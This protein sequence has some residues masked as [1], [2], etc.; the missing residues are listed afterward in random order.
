MIILTC[1]VNK[2][3]SIIIKHFY[4]ALSSDYICLE[5]IIKSIL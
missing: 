1:T 3:G 5:L 4:L 2:M